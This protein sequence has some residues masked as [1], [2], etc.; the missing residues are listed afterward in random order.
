VN[1]SALS[2]NLWLIRR[3]NEVKRT[4]AESKIPHFIYHEMKCCYLLS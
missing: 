3:T 2:T 1:R 4:T